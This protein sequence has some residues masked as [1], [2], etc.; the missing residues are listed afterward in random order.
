M[1]L[2]T[3]YSKFFRR[4][5]V[6]ICFCKDEFSIYNCEQLLSPKEL[7]FRSTYSLNFLSGYAVLGNI[8]FTAT[9]FWAGYMQQIIFDGSY[10]LRAGYFLEDLS[11]AFNFFKGRLLTSPLSLQLYIP[12]YIVSI[13][14]TVRM[15][16]IHSLKSIIIILTGE[17]AVIHF[18][19]WLFQH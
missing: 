13:F 3:K 10:L 18:F 8:Y 2:F 5:I 16:V 4:A 6:D 15:A 11:Y 19:G 7:L 17:L 9:F 12:W 1:Q 14:V